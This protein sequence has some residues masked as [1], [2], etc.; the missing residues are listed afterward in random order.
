MCTDKI[1]LL[2]YNIPNWKNDRKL[3]L[4]LCIY[5]LFVLEDLSILDNLFKILET[6]CVLTVLQ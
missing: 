4:P 3:K 2:Q 1:I 5:P 6:M